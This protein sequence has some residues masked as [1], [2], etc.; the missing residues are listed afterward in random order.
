VRLPT[1]CL[2]L[3]TALE[4]GKLDEYSWGHHVELGPVA[5]HR[6]A[7]YVYHGWLPKGHFQVIRHTCGVRACFEIDH[8]IV[9]SQRQNVVDDCP[10]SIVA[11]NAR[12]THC[13]HGHEFTPENTY[14][15]RDAKGR[16]RICKTCVNIRKSKR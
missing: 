5:L 8:L 12:K 6:R 2:V 3:Q 9:G 15:Y 13:V 10:T 4:R 7:F 11:V 1:G 14:H 16:R